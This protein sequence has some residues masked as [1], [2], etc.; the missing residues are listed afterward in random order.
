[1]RSIS[2]NLRKTENIIKIQEGAEQ[3]NIIKELKTKLPDLKKLLNS[4]YRLRSR[5]TKNCF[6]NG[7]A[8]Q[9]K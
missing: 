9:F 7:V 3:K 1:M 6:D 8:R 4:S 5:I 2:I